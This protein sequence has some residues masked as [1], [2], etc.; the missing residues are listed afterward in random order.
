[1]SSTHRPSQV[2]PGETA[3][4]DVKMIPATSTSCLSVTTHPQV[5][6]PFPLFLGDIA[7]FTVVA[8]GKSWIP[9]LTMGP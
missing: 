6:S 7:E 1:M 3:E 4:V 8:A 5:L 9:E 2:F